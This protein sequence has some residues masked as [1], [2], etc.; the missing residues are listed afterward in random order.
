[1]DGEIVKN[2]VFQR[3]GWGGDDDVV[4]AGFPSVGEEFVEH[5]GIEFV[6][7]GENGNMFARSAE[8]F[9]EEVGGDGLAGR[10]SYTDEFH[11]TDGVAIVAA[12]EFGTGFLEF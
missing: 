8:D 4:G 5:A 12:E 3:F 11:I 10:A 1:M 7:G 2:V 9:V 6:V